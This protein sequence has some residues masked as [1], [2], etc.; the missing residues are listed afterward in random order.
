MDK[1]AEQQTKIQFTFHMRFAVFTT[2]LLGYISYSLPYPIFSPMFLT[3][4]H[5]VLPNYYSTVARTVILGIA[6]IMYPLGQ[7]IGSPLLGQLS[8][9]YGRKPILIISLILTAI[10]DFTVGVGIDLHHL[11]L[12]LV[13]LFLGGLFAGNIAIAQSTAAHL[14]S[15]KT[16][17]KNFGLLNVATNL[18]W[19]AGC[20]LGG[21]LADNHLVSWFNFATP[22]YFSALCYLVN[23]IIVWFAF[24]KMSPEKKVPFIRNP[25]PLSAFIAHITSP[26]LRILYLYAFLGLLASYFFFCFFALYMVQKFNYGPSQIANFEAY[27]A[28][29]L[30]IANYFLPRVTT[31]LGLIR[32]SYLSHLALALTLFIFLIPSTS[33]GLWYTVPLVG[34]FL[35]FGE[36]T[37]TLLISNEAKPEEQ[38]MAMG[39][40]RSVLVFAEIV[41]SLLGGYTAGLHPNLPFILGIF[42]ALMASF[43]LLTWAIRK[44]T[45]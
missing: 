25:K 36:V 29:P 10:G 11:W 22:F 23:I 4:D 39:T 1:T 8:D 40:Y 15:A 44:K 28:V 27:L 45:S 18:G 41:A 32:T 16:K 12:I 17:T 33:S 34:I 26:H 2:V 19:I 30:I 6:M 14:S 5:A 9:K 3:T 37:S 43:V 38:G 42:I 35:T 7:F 13:S 21:K 20:L 24:P 31:R